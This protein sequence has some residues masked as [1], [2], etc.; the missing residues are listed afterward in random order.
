MPVARRGIS[1]DF[2]RFAVVGTLGFCWDTATVYT[3]KLFANLYVA[4]AA[5]FLVAATAN[6]LLNRVWTFRHQTHDAAHLQWVRFML[7]NSVGFVFNRGVFFI[8]ITVSPLCHR[9][10]VLA[11]IA[12]SFAGLT[13][14]YFL[15]KRFVFRYTQ[16]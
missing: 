5:G 15:S 7:A 2:L 1:P 10:P 13:F 12:G 3:V 6:W 14:N 11:I 16:P 9:I 8:L 4:G